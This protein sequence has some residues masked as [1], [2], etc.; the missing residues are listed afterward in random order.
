MW[1]IGSHFSNILEDWIANIAESDL[2]E[3]FEK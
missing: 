1:K 2:K 3:P